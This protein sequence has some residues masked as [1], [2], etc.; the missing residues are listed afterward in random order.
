MDALYEDPEIS[1]KKK[2]SLKSLALEVYNSFSENLLI[3]KVFKMTTNSFT[4]LSSIV[5]VYVPISL[6]LCRLITS[7]TNRAGR[8]GDLWLLRL[9]IKGHAAY[10]CFSWDAS[11]GGR[12]SPCKKS[13][14]L[15]T[16]LLERPHVGLQSTAMAE[17]PAHS[18]INHHPVTESSWTS[19]S[20]EPSDDSSPSQPLTTTTWEIPRE[21]F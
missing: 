12:R 4:A 2:L 18:Q 3:L 16:A 13:N 15:E 20:A 5:G 7:S 10:T 8:S 9:V 17:W 19:S 6:F 21:N 11:S 14:G 1:R